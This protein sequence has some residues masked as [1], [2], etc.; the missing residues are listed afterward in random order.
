MIAFAEEEKNE[1]AI[2]FLM[3]FRKLI[4]RFKIVPVQFF[5][6]QGNASPRMA[7][8]FEERLVSNH[9][10]MEAVKYISEM[11]VVGQSEKSNHVVAIA[12]QKNIPIKFYA[13]LDAFERKVEEPEKMFLVSWLQDKEESFQRTATE[14]VERLE[15]ITNAIKTRDSGNLT[16]TQIMELL[17][18]LGN[19]NKYSKVWEHDAVRRAYASYLGTVKRRGLEAYEDIVNY[20]QGGT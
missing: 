13:N 10:S 17:M 7:R 19:R 3:D 2:I 6:E 15:Y 12:K 18:D 4:N 20:I 8:E 16:G 1:G 5:T 11:L 14:F 9:P